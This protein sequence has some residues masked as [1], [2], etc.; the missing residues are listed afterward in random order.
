MNFK[1]FLKSLL[2]I[3]LLSVISC[4]TQKISFNPKKITKLEKAGY[5]IMFGNQDSD[6]KNF[7]INSYHIN[8]VIKDKK[9][10][11]IQV[12]LKDSSQIINGAEML[13]ILKNNFNVSDID[14]LVIDGI[15]YDSKMGELFFDLNSLSEP[16][17]MKKEKLQQGFPHKEWKGDM[18][19]LTL[20]K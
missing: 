7:F 3:F 10:K 19:L 15:V 18:V 13:T 8:S 12:N 20:K 11:T 6:F 9:I 2:L 17:I 14:L 16:L 5:K 1:N 4:Q